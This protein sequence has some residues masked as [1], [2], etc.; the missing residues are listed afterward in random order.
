MSCNVYTSFVVG[1]HAAF[2]CLWLAYVSFSSSYYGY[3]YQRPFLD[4]L[5]R[6]WQLVLVL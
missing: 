3:Y 5:C 2:V 6:D 4:L 1:D